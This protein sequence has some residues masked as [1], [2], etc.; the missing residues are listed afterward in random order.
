[1]VAREAAMEATTLADTRGRLQEQILG[2]RGQV[3]ASEANLQELRRK[4]KVYQA[5]A[6]SW[7]LLMR[8][9]AWSRSNHSAGARALGGQLFNYWIS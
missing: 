3:D 1:M 4:V 2:T 7:V 8:N 5:A 9:M 6:N